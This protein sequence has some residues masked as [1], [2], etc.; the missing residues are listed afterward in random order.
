MLVLLLGIIVAWAPKYFK[1]GKA[2][3][4]LNLIM[5]FKVQD[6]AAGHYLKEVATKSKLSPSLGVLR[7]LHSLQFPLWLCLGMFVPA[8]YRRK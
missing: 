7:S 2:N 1:S 8:T 4:C 6:V 3:L 5:S